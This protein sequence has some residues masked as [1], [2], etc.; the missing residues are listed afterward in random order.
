[1]SALMPPPPRADAA[2]S[3]SAAGRIHLGFL[4]PSG[5]LGRRFGS[6]GLMV[7]QFQT[8]V[9]IAASPRDEWHADSAAAA[10]Q[11][12]RAL[13]HVQRL[14]E[15][16]GRHAPLALRLRNVLPAH[17][18]LRE[19]LFGKPPAR[20]FALASFVQSPSDA[21]V[22][23]NP[24]ARHIVLVFSDYNCPTCRF[25]E[26]YLTAAVRETSDIKLAV[27]L[28]LDLEEYL[29]R[30]RGGCVARGDGSIV[31]RDLREHIYRR[32]DD[33]CASD[34]YRKETAACNARSASS[35]SSTR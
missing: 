26:P 22:I 16:C 19:L 29:L 3:V 15:R 8:E 33:E 25:L 21:P 2:V 12:D 23:G 7:D 4:D 9:S 34:T 27:L 5:T 11:L 14:R 17:A 13:A 20:P 10:A 28:T 35:A 24:A 18:G 6:L 31:H 32:L 30:D 1:M